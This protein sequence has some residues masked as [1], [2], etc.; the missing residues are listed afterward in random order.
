MD[1]ERLSKVLIKKFQY[2]FGN[3]NMIDFLTEEGYTNEE[4]AGLLGMTLKQVIEAP[5]DYMGVD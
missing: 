3:L 5:K 1:Y 4:I 2:M